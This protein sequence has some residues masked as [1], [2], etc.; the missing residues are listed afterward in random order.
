MSN[1]YASYAAPV[2][3]AAGTKHLVWEDNGRLYHARYDG[4][5]GAWVDKNTIS[6]AQGGSDIKLL[7]GNIIP[8]D[9][10]GRLHAPGLIAA[11]IQ[12]IGNAAEIYASVG[13]YTDDG[14]LEWSDAVQVSKDAVANTSFDFGI[15]QNG[16]IQVVTQKVL[17]IAD[18]RK[19]DYQNNPGQLA[20]DIKSPQQGDKDLYYSTLSIQPDQK[21]GGLFLVPNPQIS[22]SGNA[23]IPD[24]ADA[25]NF[26]PDFYVAKTNRTGS[27]SQILLNA[28]PS[29]PPQ[30]T[31]FQSARL[32]SAPSPS[33]STGLSSDPDPTTS[34][35]NP[36]LPATGG[37]AWGFDIT[38]GTTQH[39]TDGTT[40]PLPVL[41]EANKFASL[42][43]VELGINL[44]GAIK[45]K[46]SR[47][48]DDVYSVDA[49]LALSV[50]LV[51]EQE[52]WKKF[53]YNRKFSPKITDPVNGGSM[54]DPD[55]PVYNASIDTNQGFSGIQFS[56]N[57]SGAQSSNEKG[58]LQSLENFYGLKVAFPKRVTFNI[59]SIPGLEGALARLQALI[60]FSLAIGY[61]GI[62]S[63]PGPNAEAP[64]TLKPDTKPNLYDGLSGAGGSGAG[65]FQAITWL[66]AYN[67]YKKG[68]PGLG[69]GGNFFAGFNTAFSLLAAS[70]ILAASG[71][72]IFPGEF[73]DFDTTQKG[74]LIEILA[75]GGLSGSILAGLLGAEG[76]I[77][78]GFDFEFLS[79]P[80][81]FIFKIPYE[82]SIEAR[83]AALTFSWDISGDI[84]D[85]TDSSAQTTS[86]GLLSDDASQN[87]PNSEMV[88]L[89][90]AY[91]PYQGS[92]AIHENE[93]FS[94]V[95]PTTRIAQSQLLTASP[96]TAS[97]NNYAI[98]SVSVEEGGNG[99]L[100][101]ESGNFLV[102]PSIGN[103]LLMAYV[104]KGVIQQVVVETPGIGYD[105]NNP[106]LLDFSQ[107]GGGGSGAKATVNLIDQEVLNLTNDGRPFVDSVVFFAGPNAQA[108]TALIWIADGADSTKPIS[109]S[110]NQLTTR[111]QVSELAGT[112][113][114]IP[115]ALP[116]Q[117]SEGMNYDPVIAK[118]ISRDKKS[119]SMAV[120][121]HARAEAIGS[122][123]TDDV[124]GTLDTILETDI[125]YSLR[126]DNGTWSNPE[127]LI[128]LEGTDNRLDIGRLDD[129]RLHLAWVNAEANATE[130][131]I[132]RIYSTFFDPT[133]EVWSIPVA[134][135][136]TKE[137]DTPNR[138]EIASLKVGQLEGK[139]ALYWSKT[140]DTPYVISVLNDSPE[141]YYRLESSQ[142]NQSEI[143][144]GNL[145]NSIVSNLSFYD[146][147]MT[148]GQEGALSQDPDP[149]VQFNGQGAFVIGIPDKQ[150]ATPTSFSV[151]TW[152]KL[153]DT[154]AGKGIITRGQPIAI[155][156]TLPTAAL[157]Y[158]VTQGQDSDGKWFY[159]ITPDK[160]DITN[161]G[162][163]I[164]PNTLR[165]TNFQ[166]NEQ[167]DIPFNP[168]ESFAL[169][170]E[171]DDFLG[172]DFIG[173]DDVYI[174]RNTPQDVV[175][176][177]GTL[178]VRRFDPGTDKNREERI[179]LTAGQK[180][181]IGG[182]IYTIT[183]GETFT[184][185]LKAG[186]NISIFDVNPPGIISQS[187]APN[188][189]FTPD[190]FSNLSG[191]QVNGNQI[192]SSG[193]GFSNRPFVNE[194]E[195]FTITA[196]LEFDQ[197]DDW[198]LVT[199][200]NGSVVFNSGAGEISSESL[201]EDQW[202]HVVATY[203]SVTKESILH[204][205][206]EE[207]AKTTGERFPPSDN[208]ILVG[209][210]FNG[211]LDEVAIYNKPLTVAD[212]N[213]VEFDSTG[214]YV[215]AFNPNAPAGE[216]TSHFN[217]RDIDPDSAE[218]ATYYSV[219][220]GK[221]WGPPEHFAAEYK[222]TP[223]QTSLSRSPAVDIVG[224][225]GLQPDGVLDQHLQITLAF[226]NQFL[227]GRIITGIEIKGNG[228][229][230]SIN[231]NTKTPLGANL[232]GAMLAGQKLNDL[233]TGAFQHTVMAAR[234]VLDL[235]F[236]DPNAQE[237]TYY[238][239][240]F[241]MK[242]GG[243]IPP[244]D[245]VAPSTNIQG[246]SSKSSVVKAEILQKEVT[247]LA[248]VDSGVII[249]IDT[250]GAGQSLAA[251]EKLRNGEIGFAIGHPHQ[252][253][254]DLSK[255]GLVWVLPAGT[256][257]KLDE[258]TGIPLKNDDVPEEGAL[259]LGK[260]G[261]K[262]GYAMA[263][264]DIDGDGIDD[265]IVGAP[266]A[267]DKKGKI[268]VISGKYLGSGHTIN[269]AS[270]PDN[271]VVTIEGT[272]LSNA[273]FS[274]AAGDVNGNSFDDIVIGAPNALNSDGKAVGAVHLIHGG[275]SFFSGNNVIALGPDTI[276]FEG[277]R[278]T[279]KSKFELFSNPANQ[280]HSQVGYSVA[281]VRPGATSN[282]NAH[283][284]NADLVADILIGAPG[285]HQTIQFDKQGFPKG[286]STE[287]LGRY[288]SVLNHVP[289]FGTDSVAPERDLN[290][291][292][293]YL[294]F[295][296]DNLTTNGPLNDDN[297]SGKGV[298]F[299][300]SPLEDGDMRLG[301]VVT[302]AGDM[303]GDGYI[304][305][306]MAAP[307]AAGRSGLVFIF[308]G[309]GGGFKDKYSAMTESDVLIAGGDVFNYAGQ[310][311]AGVGDVNNDKID[312]LLVGV[313]QAGGAKGQ[314]YVIFGVENFEIG[315]PD[316]PTTISLKQGIPDD[317]FVFNG[318][319]AQG[320]A[321]YAVAKGFDLNGDTVGDML[322][323]APFA[324]QVYVG[325]GHPWLKKEGS[326]R[327]DN[328][329][330]DNG[331]I[332]NR[333]EG[334]EPKYPFDGRRV[335]NLG[336]INGDGYAD[337]GVAGNGD[338]ILIQFGGPTW[339]LIDAG[340]GV[341]QLS[342]FL[343]KD[344]IKDINF[345]S[346]EAIGDI[347]ND[348][349]D[350]FII[351]NSRSKTQEVHDFTIVYGGDYLKSLGSATI[352]VAVVPE[353][354]VRQRERLANPGFVLSN[355]SKELNLYKSFLGLGESIYSPIVGFNGKQS[356]LTLEESG[357][358]I[359]YLHGTPQKIGGQ[360]NTGIVKM[361]IGVL[362]GKNR[363]LF[364]DKSDN[365]VT[366]SEAYFD[367]SEEEITYLRVGDDFIM[368]SQRYN[369]AVP[370]RNDIKIFGYDFDYSVNV[371]QEHE[372]SNVW[373]VVLPSLLAGEAITTQ[374]GKKSFMVMPLNSNLKAENGQR[375]VAGIV[376][377]ELNVISSLISTQRVPMR[378]SELEF[379][380]ARDA[381]L[382]LGD[383][384]VVTPSSGGN[385]THQK[386]N[387]L[388][389]YNGFYY[390]GNR[391]ANIFGG[392][393]RTGRDYKIE[394][395]S[396]TQGQDLLFHLDSSLKSINI[397]QKGTAFDGSQG[398]VQY[399]NLSGPD[400]EE[401]LFEFIPAG[402]LNGDG[403]ADIL[404]FSSELTYIHFGNA[405]GN[406]SPLPSSDYSGDEG[407]VF[408]SRWAV[409]SGIGDINGDGYDD[410]L[411]QSPDGVFILLGGLTLSPAQR[412][413]IHNFLTADNQFVQA[414]SVFAVGDPNGDGFADFIV[415]DSHVVADSARGALRLVYGNATGDNFQST[416]IQTYLPVYYSLP[417][418]G[419]GDVN[420]D[421]YDDIIFSDPS[422]LDNNTGRV[423]I[424]LG[425]S[426][427][428]NKTTITPEEINSL[429]GKDGFVIDGLASSDSYSRAGETVS[430][431]GDM[432]GDGF[433]DFIIGAP[434]DNGKVGLT[435]GLFGG[436]FNKSI[437]QAGTLGNDV[438]IG[439]GAGDVI[440]GLAGD[441]TIQGN[442]GRDVLYGG[443]G[444]DTI[445][446]TDTHF[447]RVD[448]GSGFN[449]LKLEGY[450]RQ[451]WD[452]TPLSPGLRLQN[453][454]AIDMTNYGSN[455]LTLNKA[456][457]MKMTGVQNNLVILGD[458]NDKIILDAEFSKIDSFNLF[459][460][461]FDRYQADTA[462]V[463]VS[464]SIKTEVKFTANRINQTIGLS[465]AAPVTNSRLLS[466]ASPSSITTIIPASN[467]Q[468]TQFF[469]IANPTL[470]DA[471]VFT[472][473]VNRSGDL[474]KSVTALYQTVN[475]TAIAGR[476][477]TAS[478]GTLVFAPGEISKVIEVPLIERQEFGG[479]NRS[480][481][482]AV[483]PVN[484]II[485][486]EFGSHYIN[487]QTESDSQLRN[488][489]KG[490]LSLATAIQ[491][492]SALPL[493]AMD[494]KVT[495]P[496]GKTIIT[497]PFN[498]VTDINSYFRF[499]IGNGQYE[500]FLYDGETGVEFIDSSND[501]QIDTMRVH[502]VDGGR[503]DND[504]LVNGVITGS[505]AP[506]QVTPGPIQ[507]R[508]GLF[509]I[510][511]AADGQIQFHYLKGKAGSELGLIPVDDDT[512]RIGS[513][514]PNDPGYAEAALSRKIAIFQN[515]T[516]SNL[517]ALTPAIAK[518][519][520]L[521][522]E[523]L[524]QS[525]SQSNGSF[526]QMALNGNQH[527]AFYLSEAGQTSL[528]FNNPS[529]AL[530]HEGRGFF[531]VDW[532]GL[533][534]EMGTPLMITPGTVNQRVEVTFDLARGGAFN[535]TI[536]LFKVDTLTGQLDLNG[537]GTMDLAPGDE[538]YVI[539]ALNRSQDALT[540]F[541][542]P[543]V[544]SIF[545]VTTKT[546]TLF[547]GQTY[548][549]VLVT[550]GTIDDFLQNNPTNG[551]DGS[552][553]ALFSFEKGNA[554]GIS[555][556][557]RLGN[558][559]WGFEDLLGGGDRDYNDMVLQVTFANT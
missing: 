533:T 246:S 272:R 151:E 401:K 462:N 34:Q 210:N 456:T 69:G 450:R 18:P 9:G 144:Y 40:F 228:N 264:G 54:P 306:S 236:D 169:R 322:L 298:I 27:L 504:G 522:P 93:R 254:E 149:A 113:W 141:L 541:V 470:E 275:A 265:L 340:F 326:V 492:N 302:S 209:H 98:G 411:T 159:L 124:A 465:N 197:V 559:L 449:T 303:N 402:D 116:L 266:E 58:E 444:D 257:K 2:V 292:R 428:T 33:F 229:T 97:Q 239:V 372:P 101:G 317:S 313:P 488:L 497:Q 442:G 224:A 279:A 95:S 12:G 337:S 269:L 245:N 17:K 148:F 503:G 348:G 187:L 362:D 83:A 299:D 536:A 110:A 255:K 74:L 39:T 13:R 223:T 138:S 102:V 358:L 531:D 5:A 86:I 118:F 514:L 189:N 324:N 80:Q 260:N 380:S 111:V 345:E 429:E 333:Y 431:G 376:D 64:F 192:L 164:F 152:V 459:G 448:G 15:G 300:G 524:V 485:G 439:T 537:D 440:F 314:N 221:K 199:G 117:G 458:A 382:I 400:L 177:D 424:L 232:V 122:H 262:I 185:S 549:M 168:I 43:G 82:L 128:T 235:Y 421:G 309:R 371:V 92:T 71:P 501:G 78:T 367:Q 230:W 502:L 147:N 66:T 38:I 153:T 480:F 479:N 238:S 518:N 85:T 472:F 532:D 481:G 455:T 463:L 142:I 506:A 284:F 88:R 329:A 538:N 108:Y 446:I 519:S 414:P 389:V 276:L 508:P 327:L 330:N 493:G 48:S 397:A 190:E 242:D 205:N 51:K 37:P 457:V 507:T 453:I 320:L 194:A 60:Q 318:G 268:Y 23:D 553:H 112:N 240:T 373:G 1:P 423:Y 274:V 394:W 478:L 263:V 434:G 91:S 226:P 525:E 486:L 35:S 385:F 271:A 107:Y 218:E 175:I 542:V 441:D 482:L 509:Y 259:I 435:Y 227:L 155:P 243:T 466:A 415:R 432:N 72:L 557:R 347:N 62:G 510:P 256:N 182:Q 231:Q 430:G 351:Y 233:E 10:S 399:K 353:E 387:L 45:T 67:N 216:I 396:E 381:Y 548:G 408:S 461:L 36:S 81:P 172:L 166:A 137:V 215:V 237:A 146:G 181:Q 89:K 307:E 285:Y 296:G 558:N 350:D 377:K 186:D 383:D 293:A 28:P 454:S 555:H 344:V 409:G 346:I 213:A 87:D 349:F 84:V 356:R 352:D 49:D 280:W 499:N 178:I 496:G 207:V 57:F 76:T 73:N 467:G 22:S 494:F 319:I 359:F 41:E 195:S 56:L 156:A 534:M 100:G 179:E 214:K 370:G 140:A 247:S 130:G 342:V 188:F 546:T 196:D 544:D 25:L 426:H 316:F 361:E 355:S 295:G 61:Q 410:L 365:I 308:G 133:E 163:D 477:Y 203:N 554:D 473:T 552:I 7:A 343:K 65:L 418:A 360:A 512:G 286:I 391:L 500:E 323:S 515:S 16:L 31:G 451:D 527:Y 328:L 281:V 105:R 516:G 119:S 277:K 545:T 416:Q 29:N 404:A 220:D 193:T 290:T 378:T 261:D 422:H 132:Q 20:E 398:I 475:D 250:V 234:E 53:G 114:S 160:V 483:Q 47:D 139:P 103:A 489:D 104:E 173:T 331:I 21:T 368:L 419:V 294:I 529:F 253:D 364:K 490:T 332:I 180:I 30:P 511:T 208:S 427:L 52:R 366:Y 420:G 363:L 393:S 198:Y 487:L 191:I 3:D 334:S 150:T 460:T 123:S 129:G 251:G 297:L 79:G 388:F 369:Y 96:S 219:W 4:R 406:I 540:G 521:S 127:K 523:L 14:K 339:D 384:T 278:G 59:P 335:T 517:N 336:D 438:L 241:I 273:G 288:R 547:G 287:Q 505:D 310:S 390:D 63:D 136:P 433:S 6:N 520:F 24:D 135:D 447:Q 354:E 556:V 289:N 217:A 145:G 464:P 417:V 165:V 471:G 491:L 437:N 357:E 249:D 183:A 375:V 270:L 204:I 77:S 535:N 75:T 258:L 282:P 311:L 99:Y 405:S 70:D 120:W 321:G 468:P 495:A 206:G 445:I 42:F 550:N 315:K 46:V 374:D 413:S 484:D 19:S 125:Y 252:L 8:V 530:E 131:G 162:Q 267:D 244:L 32:L 551:L 392:A 301:E 407:M 474:S 425:G 11:W 452:L 44:S 403:Y 167:L 379:R 68:T 539:E 225:N 174:I 106:P 513:L 90:L 443:A 338:S 212:P 543:R 109:D 171:P 412:V 222:L 176:G 184:V 528:S 161:R 395:T 248:E 115:T 157:T 476:D 341:G 134:L 526:Q 325:F 158:K 26:N 126:I 436:D 386:G 154:T 498:G 304:D 291:G 211:F 121:A 305:I 94:P 50:E 200:E 283:S 170:A 55:N 312:D 469:V 143:N 201:D 202:H